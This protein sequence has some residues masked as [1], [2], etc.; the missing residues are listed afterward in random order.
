MNSTTAKRFSQLTLVALAVALPSAMA[1]AQVQKPAQKQAPAKSPVTRAPPPNGPVAVKPML[2]VQPGQGGCE[3]GFLW[4]ETDS[5]CNPIGESPGAG[6]GGSGGTTTLDPV[7]INSPPKTPPPPS[8]PPP[9]TNPVEGTPLAGGGV[10]PRKP[11]KSPEKIAEEKALC[12]ADK[13][14]QQTV[15][16]TTYKGAI[17]N[18]N[19]SGPPFLGDPFELLD[20]L[21]KPFGKDCLSVAAQ[22]MLQRERDITAIFEICNRRAEGG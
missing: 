6:G 20:R 18:C 4:N 11:P 9:T 19:K 1:S 15:S 14:R 10:V 3:D 22:D 2:Q 16:L 7:V 17:D 12:Q 21:R 13:E 5:T 8:P